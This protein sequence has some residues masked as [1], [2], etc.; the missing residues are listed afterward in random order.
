MKELFG[1]A[2]LEE[3]RSC[4][5]PVQNITSFNLL[6]V[7]GTAKYVLFN[8]R[9]NSTSKAYAVA[10][11]V[12]DGDKGFVIDGAFKTLVAAPHP[13]NHFFIA[14]SSVCVYSY[15]YSLSAIS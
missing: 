5:S 8:T 1:V 3:A 12:D 11:V 2:K 14:T 13:T 4:A 9:I 7:S 6:V 10:Q 15:I